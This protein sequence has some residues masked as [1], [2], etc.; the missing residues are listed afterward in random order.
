MSQ[1]S[2][3]QQK[4]SVRIYGKSSNR[5]AKKVLRLRVRRRL[6]FDQ[7]KSRRLELQR[8][9]ID[10]VAA[11]LESSKDARSTFEFAR[12][13]RKNTSNRLVLNDKEGDELRSA[14]RKLTSVTE[15]YSN[16]FQRP[17]AV[18]LPEWQGEARA[19][20]NPITGPEVSAAAARLSNNCAKGIDGLS[21]TRL[22]LSS[23]R[24]LH[25]SRFHP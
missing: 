17:D 4:L 9:H 8:T 23:Q 12:V 11:E 24:C 16:F 6:L 18:P 5:N 25:S 7:I 1:L 2:V 13:L 22:S 19:L 21:S 14:D 10:R 3:A 15:H 20:N